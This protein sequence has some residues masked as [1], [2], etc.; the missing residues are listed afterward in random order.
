MA[1]FDGVC[2]GQ[3]IFFQAKIKSFD[4]FGMVKSIFFEAKIKICFRVFLCSIGIWKH[5]V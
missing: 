3:Q 1:V 2:V 5:L 4:T